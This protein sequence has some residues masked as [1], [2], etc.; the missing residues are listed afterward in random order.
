MKIKKLELRGFKSFPNKT[1]IVI[2]P[3]IT[4]VVGPNGC[5]KTNIFEGILFALGEKKAENLRGNAW[6]DLIF[7]GNDK[8]SRSGT[9]E[10]AIVLEENDEEFEVRRKIYRD[11][12]VENYINGEYISHMK[13]ND[14]IY[15]IF[16]QGKGYALFKNEDIERIIMDAPKVLKELIH[17]A[18]GIEL[19]ERKKE[20]LRRRLLRIE[21]EMERIED[22]MLEKMKRIKELEKEVERLKVYWDIREKINFLEKKKLS[23]NYYYIKRDLV[24]KEKERE[25]KLKEIEIYKEKERKYMDELE[26][27]K[28]EISDIIENLKECEH[29]KKK[30]FDEE[31]VVLTEKAKLVERR[32]NLNIRREEFE[33]R[34]NTLSDV[35]NEI[36]REMEGIEFDKKDFDEEKFR[37]KERS[38]KNLE[39]EILSLEREKSNLEIKKLSL[40]ESLRTLE[41]RVTKNRISLEEE[42]KKEKTLLKEIEEIKKVEDE[43]D[44]QRQEIVKTLTPINEK[45]ELLEKNIDEIKVSLKSFESRVRQ[46]ESERNEKGDKFLFEFLDLNDEKM[47]VFDK[48]FY[49][50]V[51]GLK[52]II[53]E[54]FNRKKAIIEE[55]IKEFVD[56]RISKIVYTGKLKDILR[57]PGSLEKDKIYITEDGYIVEDGIVIEKFKKEK[58]EREKKIKK[59]K[60]NILK[61][62]EKLDI[63]LNEDKEARQEKKNI[64]NILDNI[65]KLLFEKKKEL[66][67]KETE[68][69]IVRLSIKDFEKRI[70]EDEKKLNDLKN[71]REILQKKVDEMTGLLN[72]KNIEKEKTQQEYNIME[73]I[74]REIER[75]KYLQK[76]KEE[77]EKE[78]KEIRQKLEKIESEAK[79]I[80]KEIDVFEK[81]EDEIAEIKKEFEQR[82]EILLEKEKNLEE[83]K[84]EIMMRI[85]ENKNDLQ[86]IK[87]DIV[88]IQVRVESVKEKLAEFPEDI[89]ES[90]PDMGIRKIE[91]EIERLK[92]R[93]Y[94]FEDVNLAAGKE[95]EKEKEEYDKITHALNDVRSSREKISS[96]IEILEEEAKKRFFNIYNNFKENIK[97]VAGSLLKGDVQVELEN[98]D[99]P[100][101]SE[102]LIKASPFG[103]RVRAL[104]LLSGGERALLALSIIFALHQVSPVPFCVL[105]EVDAALDDANT[106]RFVEFIKKL[107]YNTQ[108]FI[109]THNK[110]TMESGDI[111]Y[112]VSMEDGVSRVFSLR[113]EEVS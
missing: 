70:L 13:W 80:Q 64:I 88:A 91:E 71:E 20:T 40:E 82:E 65:E 44:G 38:L 22:L 19:F 94:E 7:S 51:L 101:N 66:R 32:Q 83:K 108:L 24:R 103:K 55:K 84:E 35:L 102:F 106:L 12:K 28:K 29:N 33:K 8:T 27:L 74:F 86:K 112:G 23:I 43:M 6:Q 16:P 97:E 92:K 68:I 69:E 60:T 105:D 57:N 37:D 1:E 11:G 52:E 39:N 54:D 59:L 18:S 34:T 95:Y 30:I 31:R 72:E 26:D 25:E 3:R 87:E 75:F 90:Y 9:A 50:P 45:L 73:R 110:R 107:S 63:L 14:R 78:L 99:D 96:A 46:L 53:S 85:E 77:T 81:K 76:T 93:L 113:L 58:V 49:Y 100:L 4:I 104:P 10:V 42:K 36:N 67:I 61:E 2:S 15:E 5:G 41:D 17:S 48:L 62:K 56:Y 98:P 47:M 79:S 21:R 109:I 111:L 89:E